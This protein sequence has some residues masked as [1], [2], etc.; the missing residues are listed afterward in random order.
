[1]LEGLGIGVPHFSYFQMANAPGSYVR[2]FEETCIGAFGFAPMLFFGR[3]I[4]QYNWGIVPYR[5]PINVVIGKPIAVDKV[6]KW[7]MHPS[8]CIQVQNLKSENCT[9]L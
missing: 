5:I 1:M 6:R 4:F 9:S 8:L 7:F 3:G 2:W